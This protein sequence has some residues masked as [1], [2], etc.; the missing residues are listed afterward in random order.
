MLRAR[1]ATNAVSLVTSARTAPLLRLV[2]C[3]LLVLGSD[4][5]EMLAPADPNDM[6]AVPTATV[7]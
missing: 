1:P 4:T 5:D 3:F 6:A 2:W 7:A